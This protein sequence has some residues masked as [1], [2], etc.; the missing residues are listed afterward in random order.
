[1]S[2][3]E[4]PA[5][6]DLLKAS[7]AEIEEAVK[8]ADAMALRGLLYQ[9]TGDE[10]LK[11]VGLKKVLG[12]YLERNVLATD[13]DV[14]MVRR[15]AADFLKAYR[16]SGAG[17]I[18]IGPL[19]RLPTSL[20]LMRGETIPEESLGLYIEETALDPWARTPQWRAT[21]DPKRLENFHVVI[22]G[23][24][25]GGLVSA[26]HCKRAGIPYTV[27]EKNAG[28][29]ASIRPAVPT[30]TCSGSI[31]PMP[32]RSRHGP[33]TSVISVGSRTSSTCARTWCSKPRSIRSPGMRPLRSGRSSPPTS[34]AWRRCCAPMR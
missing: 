17:P 10:E 33:R 12:G 27:I 13:E 25:M 1:M 30:R 18:D 5:R 21:P 28:V 14:A 15:K 32:T 11:Q 26:L 23:A 31:S 24:G 20:G 8:F 16:D 34:R 4:G 9:L 29:G 3:I 22:V 19:D 7:D 2:K 6:P